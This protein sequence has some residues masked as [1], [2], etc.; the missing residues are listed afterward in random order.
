MKK[1][2]ALKIA[3]GD[4]VLVGTPGISMPGD[5]FMATVLLVCGD[6]I[7]TEHTPAGQ[8]SPQR[9]FLPLEDVRAVGPYAELSAFKERARLA[10]KDKRDAVDAAGHALHRAREDVWSKLDEIGADAFDGRR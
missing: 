9:Q 10:V 3:A 5:W 4:E 2:S 7:A 8:S 6:E 1:R